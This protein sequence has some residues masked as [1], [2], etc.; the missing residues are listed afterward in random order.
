M[1]LTASCSRRLLLC[2]AVAF[3][4][5][6]IA[7]PVQPTVSE[8]EDVLQRFVQ[9]Q[10][11]KQTFDVN[12]IQARK[13]AL[14][15]SMMTV[16]KIVGCVGREGPAL[17]CVALVDGGRSRNFYTMLSVQW[18]GTQWE[19]SPARFEDGKA[20]RRLGPT[21]AQAQAA[22][23]QFA[24]AKLDKRGADGEIEFMATGVKVLSI[25]DDCEIDEYT[26]TVACETAFQLPAPKTRPER[27]FIQR[28]HFYIEGG[29]W[30]FGRRAFPDRHHLKMNQDPQ[31]A[32]LVRF[33]CEAARY[34]AR[35]G[36]I[37]R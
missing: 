2:V 35:C 31:V 26:G 7:A 30:Q 22:A 8:L 27:Q 9:T 21:A 28:S 25:S 10:F 33:S 23:R 16:K 5:P 12:D 6:A 17:T 34:G 32:G 19:E 15:R 4:A 14:R 13:D 18:Q 24:Q 20:K 37:G 11:A 1:Y 29:A 3:G 36:T